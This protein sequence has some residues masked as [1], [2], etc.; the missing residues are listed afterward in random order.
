VVYRPDGPDDRAQP[1]V[2]AGPT[3]PLTFLTY[4]W[5]P[6]P[7]YHSTFTG[8]HVSILA[9][10]LKRHYAKPHRFICYT[11][12]DSGVDPNL[13]ETREI[14]TDYADLADF[15]RASASCFRRLKMLSRDTSAWLGERIVMM[16]LDVVIVGDLAPPLDRPED[17][18]I[19]TGVV[20]F[21]P[22]NGSL[23]LFTVGCRTQ[24]WEEFRLVESLAFARSL[25]QPHSDDGW[26]GA[27]L[28]PDSARFTPEDGVYDFRN[29]IHG[30]RDTLPGNAAIVIFHGKQDPDGA[31][32]QSYGWVRE[33]YR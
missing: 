24:L 7:G 32:A 16:D 25:G 5:R 22:Y 18:V 19:N 30:K 2:Q 27:R 10:M 31:L 13:V 28:D 29:H 6:K 15:A 17:F 11:G 14:W 12:D 8:E 21:M 9:R 4:K 33:N 3:A 23:M 20:P 26:I 1:H